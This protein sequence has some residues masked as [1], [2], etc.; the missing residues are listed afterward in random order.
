MNPTLRTARNMVCI[1]AMALALAGCKSKQQQAIDDA[2]KQAI[3]TGQPQQVMLYDDLRDP[4]ALLRGETRTKL[5]RFWPYARDT[6]HPEDESEPADEDYAAYSRL[7]SQSQALVA[8]DILDA[9]PIAGHRRLLD[10]GGG[11]GAFL[12]RRRRA[13]PHSSSCFSTF[14]LS[15]RAPDPSSQPW[16]SQTGSS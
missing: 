4:V 11:E 14:R 7:M 10:I 6:L 3:A 9:Y 5:S 13:R 12:A 16:A 8:Q 15:S 1:A 2:T